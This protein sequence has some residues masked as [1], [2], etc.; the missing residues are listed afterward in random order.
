MAR[1]QK[2]RRLHR[3]ARR[4]A[5]GRIC[6]RA[7]R[8]AEMADRLQRVGRRRAC[9][10]QPRASCSWTAATRCRRASRPIPSV[11]QI[12]SLITNPPPE[13]LKEN[14]GKGLRLGFDPWLHTISEVK[15]LRR[16]WRRRS[17]ELVA[18]DSNPID[19]LWADR[20]DAPLQPVEIQPID[21]AGE[22]AKEKLA[23]LGRR[24]RESRRHACGADRP[25]F[26]RLGLQYSRPRR[27]AYAAGARLRH[28]RGGWQAHVFIDKRKLPITHRSLSH[29]ALGPAIRHRRWSPI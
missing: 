18:V 3:A 26:A 21:F 15:A 2:P 14:V 23:R 27:A 11:F 5:S 6:R 16:R 20:P 29:P 9:P 8:A 17:A 28:P 25:F 1:R 12:E 10:C 22:L 19:E 13:W 7:L 4:R 24:H